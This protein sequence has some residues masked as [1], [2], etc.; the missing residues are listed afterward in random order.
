MATNDPRVLGSP[1][2]PRGSKYALGY[3]MDKVRMHYWYLLVDDNPT[4]VNE[5]ETD[6]KPNCLLRTL[7]GT[8]GIFLVF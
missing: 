7:Q 2:K 1:A 8:F 4:N 3:R 5:S 6:I